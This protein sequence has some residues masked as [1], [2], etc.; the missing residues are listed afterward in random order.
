MSQTRRST[1]L[2]LSSICALA[3]VSAIVA[4][5]RAGAATGTRTY[6]VKSLRTEGSVWIA[7]GGE[8]M[9]EGF[10]SAG[11]RLFETNI[12]RRGDGVRGVFVA[13]VVVASP[14][15]VAADHAVGLANGV[16]RFHDGQIFVEGFVSFA[17]PSATG[18]I[19]GGTGR[20]RGAR[21]TFSST[22]A[23]DVLRVLR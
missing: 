16:Y 12:V 9:K 15:T 5:P 11:N 2:L 23:R 14:G 4:L 19:V 18:V 3:A 1:W 17:Q 21:G 10:L 7:G 6:I 22:E 20:F 13:T 8:P